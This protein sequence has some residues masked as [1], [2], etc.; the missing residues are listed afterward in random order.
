MSFSIQKKGI[1]HPLLGLFLVL[2]CCVFF[3][4]LGFFILFTLLVGAFFVEFFFFGFF[5]GVLLGGRVLWV[6]FFLFL[7]TSCSVITPEH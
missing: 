6:I 7:L 4:C 3:A 1:V 5:W 2:F